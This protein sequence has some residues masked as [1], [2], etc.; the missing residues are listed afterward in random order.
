MNIR[1]DEPSR[2]VCNMST[3]TR[4]EPTTMP[5]FPSMKEVLAVL[6]TAPPDLRVGI[7]E[8]A[9]YH[10]A[11]EKDPRRTVIVEGDV[12]RINREPTQF[13]SLMLVVED[14]S[15]EDL[16]AEGLTVWVP[17]ELE[18]AGQLDF[19]VGSRIFA[20]GRT[21]IGPGFNRDTGQLDASIERIMLN[22]VAIIALPEF[23]VP[24]EEESVIGAEVV[25]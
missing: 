20:I 1:A 18:E 16:E 4:F 17:E 6:E 23:R 13:G 8:L 7:A 21:T 12:S 11:F 24:P 3:T 25:K 14:T 2:F 22:A 19:G 10:K 9:E 5:E 15:K